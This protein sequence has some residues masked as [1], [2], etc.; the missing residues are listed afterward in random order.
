MNFYLS[1]GSLGKLTLNQPRFQSFIREDK[2]AREEIFQ[3]IYILRSLVVAFDR[4]SGKKVWEK[5]VSLSSLVS[6]SGRGAV[7]ARKPS[8]DKEWELLKQNTR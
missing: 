7:C 1:A 4:L 8:T 2:F 6:E 3:L 5:L